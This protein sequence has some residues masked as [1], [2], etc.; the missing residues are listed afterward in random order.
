MSA[1]RVRRAHVP[2]VRE[3][4]GHPQHIHGLRLRRSRRLPTYLS[5]RYAAHGVLDLQQTLVVMPGARAGRRLLELLVDHAEA[6]QLALVP[7]Q[8]VT[9]G[10]LLN[11]STRRRGLLRRP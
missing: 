1:R 5:E 4:D 3:D 2:Y 10:Q 11:C 7:P 6:R 9:I 8:I